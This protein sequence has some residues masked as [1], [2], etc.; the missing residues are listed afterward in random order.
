VIEAQS[1]KKKT[2]SAKART[3]KWGIGAHEIRWQSKES[4]ALALRYFGCGAV[5]SLVLSWDSR[6]D[7]RDHSHS[8][9]LDYNWIRETVPASSGWLRLRQG[10]AGVE[11]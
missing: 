3:P 10:V 5:G 7:G 11:L 6:P 2:R 9:R 8:W 4:K 1:D